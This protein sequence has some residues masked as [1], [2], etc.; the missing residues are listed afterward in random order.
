MRLI[1]IKIK[2]TTKGRYMNKTIQAAVSIA[3]A[4]FSLTNTSIANAT[5]L[6]YDSNTTISTNETNN[7]DRLY[8]GKNS[9]GI[10]LIINSHF[11]LPYSQIVIGTTDGNTV[12]VSGLSAIWE[13]Q[14][15]TENTFH[16]G[17]GGSNNQLIVSNGGQ[18]KILGGSGGHDALI[19][20]YTGSDNNQMTVKGAGSLF[21]NN[22]TFYI[23]RLG[24][25]NSLLIDNG[26][27]VI[28]NNARIGGGCTAI[29]CVGVAPDYTN[30][31]GNSVI[32]NGVGS[33]W[34]IAGKLRVGGGITTTSNSNGLSI[35][36]GGI[37]NVNSGM[38]VGYD[39]NSANNFVLVSG[40]NSQLNAQAIIVGNNS[41]SSG[42]SITVNDY[43]SLKAASINYNGIN[44]SLNLNR[45]AIITSDVINSTSSTN[46]LN[47]NLG[48]GASY[49]YTVTG[50][51]TVTDLDNRPMVTG[52]AY[53]A[54]IGAQE[55]ASQMLYQRTSAITNSL[56]HR[57]RD[58]ATGNVN[59]A[60]YWLEVY[61]GNVNRS[62]GASNLTTTH[63]SNNNY[64]IT[65]GF[66]LPA[67]FTP[68]EFI[69]N[70]EQSDLNID[71]GNQ[72]IDSTSLMAGFLA[73]SIAEVGGAKLSA[74]ALVGF[75]NNNGD[76]KVMTNS[77]LYNGSQQVTSDFN[78]TYGVLGTALTKLY[79]INDNLTA[80]ILLG[81]DLVAERI[82][83]YSESAYFAWDSRTLTQLQSRLQGGIE[84]R[85]NDKATVFARLGAERRD[86]MSG[87]V[88]DYTINGTSVSFNTNNKSD[89]YF[90]GQLGT[91]IQLEKRVQFFGVINTVNS[92][93]NVSSVQAN[94]GLRADF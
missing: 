31:T 85:F 3:L 51:W 38:F 75:A 89:T 68:L 30:P 84:Y 18:V 8:V 7:A 43:G 17:Y 44:G 46:I 66:K 92:S 82:N 86:L 14:G 61:G 41:L 40:Q 5:D 63:F 35:T 42:N 49:A 65:A 60:P 56:D 37:V 94:L 29:E 45:G 47:L 80:D 79:P 25:N 59:S 28:S 74:K 88:Q 21:E 87:E 57:L 54:G 53:A 36:N 52:S 6:I 39:A 20:F 2:C 22:A 19:G 15:L 12:S 73:P 70:A 27:H 93:D 71:G 76:R 55:T 64:G 26:G 34:D 9:E 58:Y 48:S 69:V 23:G 32:V 4:T 77:T 78:G 33:V 62:E 24:N 91:R 67:E 50:L 90:T 72:K 83:S 10:N 13:S 11:T 16:L 1:Q 81:L